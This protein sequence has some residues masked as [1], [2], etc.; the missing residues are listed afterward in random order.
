[1]TTDPFFCSLHASLV[2]VWRCFF[3][4]VC[5]DADL[6]SMPLRLHLE[7]CLFA[8]MFQHPRNASTEMFKIWCKHLLGLKGELIRFIDF[9]ATL[10]VLL[11]W[12]CLEGISSYMPKCW[13]GLKYDFIRSWWSVVINII[14][15]CNLN[16][17]MLITKT[18]SRLFRSSVVPCWT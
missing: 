5:V 18:N 10:S 1:M 9:T 15:T 4:C 7:V 6:F 2:G 17:N 16:I 11:F 12:M 14:F 13:L 8:H 3:E